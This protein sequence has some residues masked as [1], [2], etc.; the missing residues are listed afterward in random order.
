[1]IE[2]AIIGGVKSETRIA[3]LASAVPANLDAS[4]LPSQ[5]VLLKW[6]RN[7]TAQG[8]FIVNER[9]A[10]AITEQ[11]SG[12]IRDRVMLDYEHSSEPFHP[13]YIP[14]PRKHAAVGQPA[15]S[16]ELG[17]ALMALTWT[18]SGKEFALEYPDLSPAVDFDPSTR[19]VTGLRSAALC[20]Q[21]AAINGT[22]F[23][24]ADDAAMLKTEGNPKMEELLKA[25]QT[26]IDKLTARI[27]ALETK[28]GA[29]EAKTVAAMSASE[30]IRTQFALLSAESGK[31]SKMAV[32]DQA[33]REGKVI[34]LNESS[35]AALS[36]DDLKAHVALLK[37]GKVPL[38]PQTAS[39]TGTAALDADTLMAQY[40][41]IE[42]PIE[43]AQFFKAH[44]SGMG[45]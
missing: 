13:R 43:R 30:E 36:L 10:A 22:A 11:V 3:C 23:F 37:P 24:S 44:S 33:K 21:G 35:I 12:G 38:Q 32:I 27:D 5:L 6:G 41:A 40:N 31:A 25:A 42:D 45:L 39:G 34:Q 9:T 7:E 20:K 1:M 17:L 2:R 28:L 19:V 4:A 26:A 18:P 16:P 8:V 29:A 15:C 14:P